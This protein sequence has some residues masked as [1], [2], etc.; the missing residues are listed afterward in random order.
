MAQCFTFKLILE[1]VETY[2]FFKI[3]DMLQKV[4]FIKKSLYGDKGEEREV[5]GKAAIQFEKLGIIAVK[6]DKKTPETKEDKTNIET[7]EEKQ[8]SRD[9]MGTQKVPKK[10]TKK[11]EKTKVTKAPK[12]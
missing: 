11:I 10:E 8:N 7:K 4:I 5:T 3:L 6:E 1:G 12:L 2:P 9:V